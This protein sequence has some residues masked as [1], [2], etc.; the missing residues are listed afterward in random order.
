MV[1]LPG[2]AVWPHRGISGN[3]RDPS[4]MDNRRRTLYPP[5]ASFPRRLRHQLLRFGRLQAIP[6]P[7]SCPGKPTDAL[8]SFLSDRPKSIPLERRKGFAR[9]EAHFPP[10]L[11]ADALHWLKNLHVTSTRKAD[12][13]A[14]G[15]GYVFGL[16]RG[17]GNGRFAFQGAR[18]PEVLDQYLV[19]VLRQRTAFQAWPLDILVRDR[20]AFWEFLDERWPVFVRDTRGATSVINEEPESLKYSGPALLPFHHDDVRVFIDNLFEDG[21]LT[22]IPWSWDDAGVHFCRSLFVL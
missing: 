2:V 6:A 7:K 3:D 20:K 11:S 5:P 19:T 14:C 8:H 10:L 16:F 17:Y 12:Y 21:I 4:A 9:L 13:A 22:P 15:Q 18:V 1:P